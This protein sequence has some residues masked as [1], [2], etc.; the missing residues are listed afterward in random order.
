MEK[1]WAIIDKMKHGEVIHLFRIPEA[2]RELFIKCI[3]ERID[4][5]NDCEFNSDYTKVKKYDR[6]R[7]IIKSTSKEEGD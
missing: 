1:A 3:K 5:F 7:K 6:F 2:R 4:C